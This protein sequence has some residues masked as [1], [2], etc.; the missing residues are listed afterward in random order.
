MSKPLL[1]LEVR[2]EH[3]VVLARQRARQL[4][5]LLAFE[6]QDQTRLATAVSEIARNAFQYAGGGKVEFLV[7]VQVPPAF[8]IRV[9]DRGPGIKDL[10]AILDG[11]YSSPTGMGVGLAGVR[12]LMDHFAVESAPGGGTVVVLGKTLPRAPRC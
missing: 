2:L 7:E 1:S 8:L 3:D 12:R 4:A 11:R 9:S 5:G 10:Q 6:A